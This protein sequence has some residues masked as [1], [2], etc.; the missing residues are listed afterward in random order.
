MQ[1]WIAHEY[2]VVLR[3]EQDRERHRKGIW[4]LYELV[5]HSHTCFRISQEACQP[6]NTSWNF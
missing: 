3:S 5:L 1:V 2:T 6:C 4:E